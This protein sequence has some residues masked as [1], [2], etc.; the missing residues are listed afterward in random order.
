MTEF[1]VQTFNG[2]TLAGIIF[3]VSSG[4]TLVF[5]VMRVTNLAHGAV[6]L[7]GGYVAYSAIGGHTDNFFLGLIAGTAA[8]AGLGLLME[9]LLLPWLHHV[10]MAE[11][12][13]TLGLVYVI[14]D[15]SLA[16]WGGNPLSISLPGVLGQSSVLPFDD[17]VYPNGR[18]FILGVAL[19]VGILLYLMLRLTRIGAIIRAGVDDRDMVNAMGINVRRVF[20]GVF[21]LGAALAGFAGVL[22]VP[23]L[24][25]YTGGDTNIL[26]FALAVV[27][28][29]G[30]GSYEGAII[31]SLIIGL[32]DTYGTAYFPAVSY[33][34]LFI[35]LVV[36]ML[37][38]PQGILGRAATA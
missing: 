30:L 32:I 16:I 19:V 35:P 15:V 25:L 33:T 22:G 18:F 31:G 4:F 34:V 21:V 10:E 2:L 14:D 29:G 3:L 24:G 17:I 6:F 38:R 5:G 1:I 9:K 37:V 28:V 20:T 27:V 26:L 8:M 7:L 36:I 12:L 13:A 11:L 23:V